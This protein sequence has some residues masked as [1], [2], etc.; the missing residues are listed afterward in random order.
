MIPPTVLIRTKDWPV[1]LLSQE[2]PSSLPS[3]TVS[4][5][6]DGTLS[7]LT[8]SLSQWTKSSPTPPSARIN[9]SLSGL[10]VTPTTSPTE[11]K[12]PF[13]TPI[14]TTTSETSL[15]S[16][17]S[18]RTTGESS[19]LRLSSME[20]PTPADQ[21]TRLLTLELPFSLDQLMSSRRSNTRSEESHSSMESTKLSAAR[22]HLF[23]TSPSTSEDKTSI[24][25]ERTTSFKCPTETE[26][27]PASLDSWEWI[28]QPQPDH[29]GFSETSSSDASTRSSI[30][31]TRELDLPP[32]EPE[33]KPISN[34]KTQ[35]LC[36][37][38]L[39]CNKCGYVMIRSSKTVLSIRLQEF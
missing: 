21:S 7:L 2:S 10:A 8:R 18:L 22:F 13:A 19:S 27:P 26:D 6:W 16:H 9:Y 3:L 36:H 33:N 24:F 5:E 39:D 14:R 17:S 20:P 31:E 4:S 32:L 37:Y 12:L 35:F 23:Q 30:M 15:G 25:K 29:S 28:F 11:E 38:L 1:L 34:L